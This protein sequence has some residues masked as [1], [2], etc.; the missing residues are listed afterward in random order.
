[1]NVTP[2]LGS[3][4]K[5]KVANKFGIQLKGKDGSKQA[6]QSVGMTLGTKNKTV[7][8]FR[9]QN[10]SNGLK[11]NSN[12]T[13]LQSRKISL[14]P[15]PKSQSSIALL[16]T[17]TF[18][19]RR[20]SFNSDVNHSTTLKPVKTT[21]STESLLKS[22]PKTRRTS[23]TSISP[24]PSLIR[25]TSVTNVIEQPI[26]IIKRRSITPISPEPSPVRRISI[27]KP[28]EQSIPTSSSPKQNSLS[29]T[30]AEIEH[31][32]DQ[33]LYKRQLTKTL[34]NSTSTSNKTKHPYELSTT[35]SR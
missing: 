18:N 28:A 12:S 7:S 1:M 8:D 6:D 24:E 21:P 33:P 16:S 26:S 34:E 22:P 27:T 29:K 30:E 35:S 32:K 15:T 25:R 23:Q 31:Q 10:D 13:T 4:N 2:G 17:S 3:F 20:N 9:F 19:E 14:E 11:S 5:D